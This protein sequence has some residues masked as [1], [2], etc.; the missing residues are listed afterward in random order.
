MGT[1]DRVNILIMGY[2]GSGHDGA[3]LTDSQV[4][5]S[6]WN[7]LV[8]SVIGWKTI[9]FW[10]ALGLLVLSRVLFGLRA[11]VL[12]GEAAEWDEAAVSA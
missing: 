5:M 11:G 7:W 10:Q 4:V 12:T 6:L 9:D 8:P 2:G 3:Y 1:S